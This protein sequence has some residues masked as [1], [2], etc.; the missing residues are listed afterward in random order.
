MDV[1]LEHKL[2]SITTRPRLLTVDDQPI[3]IRLLYE[4]F[5]NEYDLFMATDGVQA[6]SKA[7]ELMPDLIL[8]DVN[9]PGM[10]GFEVCRQL[11]SDPKTAYIPIIFITGNFDEA[12]EV[13][14][15]ELGGSDFIRKPI[16]ATITRARVHTHLA[17]K[18]QA[19]QLRNFA[20]L[21]GLTGVANRR[22]FDRELLNVWRHCQRNQLPLSLLM[23]DVDYFKRYNDHY[24]HL[25]GDTCLRRV[26]VALQQALQRP[27][28][29]LARYGGE[30]FACVLPDTVAEG[31]TY[32][33]QML[34]EQVKK[35]KI[36]HDK[37]EVDPYVSVSIGMATLI[38]HAH[39]QV[40]TLIEAADQELYRAKLSGR[41]RACN[42]DLSC[43]E[44]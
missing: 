29:L 23:I 43:A 22:M 36:R 28:D 42:V 4:L 24:G 34:L 38:P 41:G 37:S 18:L 25:E 9:M 8:L 44:Q 16:N 14:G 7:H 3:N 30:E 17:L 1:S 13:R 32:V 2:T 27:Q 35:L 12:D 10:D 21:D 26:A 5:H 19:D 11:K 39:A 40:H 15:F 31:G 20:L 33:A 6:I